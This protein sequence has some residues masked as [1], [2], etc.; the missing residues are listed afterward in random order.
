MKYC[1]VGITTQTATFRNP[2]FQ[3]F[4]KSYNLPPPTTLV[5]LAGAA[6]GLSPKASQD[7][8]NQSDFKMGVYGQPAGTTTDLWKY[9]DFKTGSIVKKE[10]LFQNHFVCVYGNANDKTVREIQEAFINP[11]Y[12]LTM[13]SSD[14]VAKINKPVKIITETTSYNM[15]FCLLEGDIINEVKDNTGNGMEFSIYTTSDPITY[16]LPVRFRYDSDYGFR[17]VIERKL[18]SFIGKEM[19]LNVPKEGISYNGKFI[20]LFEY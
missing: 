19:V 3:D 9:D 13:G 7:Y 17:S 11:K 18:F 12:A 4:H 16:Q 5:G 20:P 1:V 8:F 15:E 14:S 2:E 6:L 10:I